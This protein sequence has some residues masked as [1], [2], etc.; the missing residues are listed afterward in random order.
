MPSVLCLTP[1]EPCARW[2]SDERVDDA[3]DGI[4]DIDIIL[5]NI[6]Q[7]EGEGRAKDGL[8]EVDRQPHLQCVSGASTKARMPF[9]TRL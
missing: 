5:A 1:N 8:R 6:A 3:V 2:S 9:Q 4:V 7:N